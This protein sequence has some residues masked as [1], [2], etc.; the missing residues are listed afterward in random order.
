MLILFKLQVDLIGESGGGSQHRTE[1]GASVDCRARVGGNDESLMI[2]FFG[3]DA[4]RRK[5]FDR[6]KMLST[7]MRRELSLQHDSRNDG[8]ICRN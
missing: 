7:N 4:K 2:K 1:R 8:T 6:T 3:S 5:S